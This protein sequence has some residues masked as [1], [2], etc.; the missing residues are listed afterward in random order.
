MSGMRR[1]LAWCLVG[2]AMLA[3]CSKPDAG[4]GVS[5]A[6]QAY[7]EIVRPM[8]ATGTDAQWLELR[9]GICAVFDARADAEQ[10]MAE[11]KVLTETVGLSA[12]QA[13]EVIGASTA[14]A[15]PRHNGVGP[16]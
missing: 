3:G 6:D 11:V 16:G 5:P 2:V 14:S 12:R 13:G 7:L 9:A 1:G 4:Q 8:L 10:W 15:C